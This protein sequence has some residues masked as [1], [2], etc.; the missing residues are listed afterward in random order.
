MHISGQANIFYIEDV[1]GDI[2]PITARRSR[3]GWK[4]DAR[5]FDEEGGRKEGDLVFSAAADSLSE[6]IA[7]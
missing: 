2:Q 7:V 3:K 1:N 6:R 5:V 4:I